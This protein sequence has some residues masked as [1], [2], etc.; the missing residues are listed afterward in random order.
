MDPL[1]YDIQVERGLHRPDV[2]MDTLQRAAS[3]V[4]PIMRAHNFKVGLLAEFLPKERGLLGLNT[5]GGRTIHVRLRHATDPTQF[6]TFQMI[7][8]TVLHELSHNRFGPH[9]ANFHALWDQLRDEYYALMQSGFTGGA[10]LSHGHLLSRQDEARRIARAAITDSRKKLPLTV[11]RKL[12]E[13]GPKPGVDARSRLTGAF[14][15]MQIAQGCGCNMPKSEQKALVAAAGVNVIKSR[16]E[17]DDAN[18]IAIQEALWELAQEDRASSS[19]PEGASYGSAAGKGGS[20]STNRPLSSYTYDA[21]SKSSKPYDSDSDSE[22]SE[23]PSLSK[24]PP[25]YVQLV[26]EEFWQCETCTLINKE[27]AVCCDACGTARPGTEPPPKASSSKAPT[28]ATAKK[29][30]YKAPPAKSSARTR[31]SSSRAGPS[32]QVARSGTWQC[33]C[34]LINKEGRVCCA[35]CGI[36]RP[37]S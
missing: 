12:I 33:A 31:P 25:Q 16:V 8:D 7:M 27:E 35:A 24:P 28:K 13:A 1:I 9:D 4:K 30:T 29:T 22:Y 18:E 10:F 20:L 3:L 21:S 26:D 32:R 23:G 37:G 19:K 15:R 36:A 17:K 6:F 5:G 2:A 11:N 14:G 34:S